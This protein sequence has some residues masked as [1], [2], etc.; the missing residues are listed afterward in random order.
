MQKLLFCPDSHHPYSSPVAWKC[1]LAVARGWQPD[2]CI[3]LGDFGDFHAISSHPKDPR[4]T[5]PFSVELAAVNVALDQLDDA[6]GNDCWGEYVQ[7]NH[8]TR[9]ERY[10]MDK[11]PLVADQLRPWDELLRLD[12]RGWSV[13]PYKKSLEIGH[14]RVTH[15]IGRAGVNAARQSLLD[16]GT[17]ILFG[18]THRLVCHYQ[19][20]LFGTPHVGMTCGWLGDPTAIDY[21]HRDVVLRDSIHG[22]AVAHLLDDGTFWAYPVPIIGGRCV[23]DGVLYG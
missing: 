1:F 22:F 16:A 19:G 4:R 8:E 21:R 9:L 2:G 10:V 15:D 14:L 5:L 3:I 6:L 7:G 11:A 20:Q 17:S 12:E 23:V 13:V 18:H